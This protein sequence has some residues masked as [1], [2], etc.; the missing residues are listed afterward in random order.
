[1]NRTIEVTFLREI[2]RTRGEHVNPRNRVE[3]G[4]GLRPVFQA[5]GGPR[6][7]DRTWSNEAGSPAGN[8]HRK[9]SINEPGA[10]MSTKTGAIR[11]LAKFMLQQ[12]AQ[13]SAETARLLRRRERIG[14]RTVISTVR[15]HQRNSTA[16]ELAEMN[17]TEG[18]KNLQGQRETRQP[19]Y[20]RPPR[21]EPRHEITTLVSSASLP[22]DC[23]R[24]MTSL[25]CEAA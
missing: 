15:R 25:L 3:R 18:D 8:D 1:V 14:R 16:A 4:D 9:A 24:Q 2:D 12:I 13:K 20:Y 23:V 22:S 11:V 19:R 6:A 10:K 7:L 17:K 21:P 5:C